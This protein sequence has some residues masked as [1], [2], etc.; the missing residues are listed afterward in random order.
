MSLATDSIERSKAHCR[1]W[2]LI[3]QDHC[4]TGR[5]IALWRVPCNS[6]GCERCAKKK[7]AALSHKARVNFQGSRLRFLTLTIR[8]MSSQTSA[9]LHI[10]AAWNRLRLKLNR[11]L[12]KVKYLKVMEPQ[13]GTKMPHFHVLIDKYIPWH[14]MNQ[15][16]VEAGFGP[17]WNIK[18]IR[19]DQVY[20]YVLKYLRKGISDIAFLDALLQC[21]GRRFGFSQGMA[22]IT[23]DYPLHPVQLYQHEGTPADLALWT[24]RFYEIA[25]SVGYYPISC[26]EDFVCYF[27][28]SS[29]PLLPAPPTSGST[30]PAALSVDVDVHVYHSLHTQAVLPLYRS[31]RAIG[32]RPPFLALPRSETTP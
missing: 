23:A 24:L 26:N 6:W 13:P 1:T 27:N 25:K 4:A 18:A 11:K 29:V 12:G 14:W 32:R 8:P 3:L 19:S 31:L 5:R 15:A 30:P 17:I 7:V 22:M 9:I 16:V 2:S 28:P 20:E 21:R 10:N